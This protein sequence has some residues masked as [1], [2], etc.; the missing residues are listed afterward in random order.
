LSAEIAGKPI[1]EATDTKPVRL[2]I[3]IPVNSRIR[4]IQ[5]P[6]PS[7]STGLRR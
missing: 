7:A 1:L 2:V 4:V 6:S 3:R 5:I